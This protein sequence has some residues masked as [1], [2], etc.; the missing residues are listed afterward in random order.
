MLKCDKIARLLAKGK[1]TLDLVASYSSFEQIPNDIIEYLTTEER[2]SSSKVYAQNFCVKCKSI[3]MERNCLSCCVNKTQ[4]SPAHASQSPSP[5]STH[6][7]HS[8]PTLTPL[9]QAPNDFDAVST[10]CNDL[11]ASKSAP[12]SSSD[13]DTSPLASDEDNIASPKGSRSSHLPSEDERAVKG[14]GP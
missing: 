14:W 9:E 12:M 5:S 4:S 2:N 10:E 8:E 7:D 13:E 3:I 11:Y 6:E 1:P